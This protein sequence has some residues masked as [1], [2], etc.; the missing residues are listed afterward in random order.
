MTTVNRAVI[1]RAN[2]TLA[3]LGLTRSPDLV[4]LRAPLNVTAP[5]PPGDEITQEE[6]QPVQIVLPVGCMG[7]VM[8][9]SKTLPLRVKIAFGV[10]GG[11][12]IMLELDGDSFA[13]L[14]ASVLV[15]QQ[16]PA[17]KLIS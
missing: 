1:E 10:E 6:P 16:V 17:S 15:G 14:C 11:R 8:E 12:G 13:V 3:R 2:E 9:R 7:Q 5:P 4:V